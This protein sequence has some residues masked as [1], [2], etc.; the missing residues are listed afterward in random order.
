M[1]Y[2]SALVVDRFKNVTIDANKFICEKTT[3]CEICAKAK[4]HTKTFDKTR[5]I[6]VDLINPIS[7][8]TLIK[9]NTKDVQKQM[10]VSVLRLN[11]ATY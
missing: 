9:R 11:C 8:P 10:R 4:L 3:S 2:I 1:G 6:H 7:L 5:H